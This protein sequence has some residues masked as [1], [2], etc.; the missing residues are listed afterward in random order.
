VFKIN[1]EK[2]LSFKN[3]KKTHSPKDA[4]NSRQNGPSTTWFGDLALSGK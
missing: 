2:V 3:K 4:N 1:K